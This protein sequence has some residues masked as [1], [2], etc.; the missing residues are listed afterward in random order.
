MRKLLETE[1][2]EYSDAPTTVGSGNNVHFPLRRTS[3]RQMATVNLVLACLVITAWLTVGGRQ[4]LEAVTH[5]WPVTV[6]MAFGSIVGGGTSEGGGAVAFPVLTKLLAVPPEEA[7]LF[8]FAVQSVGMGAATVS[9]LVNRVPIAWRAIGWGGPVAMIA[10]AFSVVFLAPFMP[11]RSVRLLFTAILA[12][13]MIALLVSTRFR[14]ARRPTCPRLGWVERAM[15]VGAGL[16]GGL[17]SGLAGVGENTVMF[18]LLVLGF[19][20]CERVATPT[21]VVLMT[22]VTWACFTVHVLWVGDFHGRVVDMWLAAVPIV[23]IG[24]PLGAL[25]CTRLSR[26][27]IVTV[28]CTLITVEIVSTLLLVPMSMR[29]LTAFS[30]AII[31]LTLGCITLTSLR[32]YDVDTPPDDRPRIQRTKIRAS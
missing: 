5:H 9:I 32:R 29:D 11:G 16:V 3:V 15:I 24:A 6:T 27:A 10:A 13:L 20:V 25:I 17:L 2:S 1:E 14:P 12:G 4:A 26:Q 19:R 31:V 30:A 21:T 8:S 7:R 22:M 28:L 18:I 23:A